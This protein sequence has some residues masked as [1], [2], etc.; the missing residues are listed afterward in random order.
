MECNKFFETSFNVNGSVTLTIIV[1]ILLIFFSAFLYLFNHKGYLLTVMGLF[2]WLAVFV[3]YFS[4]YL[5]FAEV[6]KKGGYSI[7][8]GIVSVIQR[9]P[10]SSGL[11][12]DDIIEVGETKFVIHGKGRTSA[13]N[14]TIAVGG[15]LDDG[16][17]ARLAHYNGRILR[18]ETCSE[19]PTSCSE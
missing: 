17:I 10:P 19:L 18:V 13:Y 8:C 5:E 15:V 14:K 6:L 16:V 7:S 4:E 12:P 9:E 1:S 11:P 2:I 3:S